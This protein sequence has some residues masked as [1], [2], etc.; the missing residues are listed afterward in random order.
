MEWLNQNSSTV[1]A[2]ATVVSAIFAGVIWWE[3]RKYRKVTER[4]KELN[5]TIVE[6]DEPNLRIEFPNEVRS[7]SSGQGK[8]HFRIP[9]WLENLCNK[10]NSLILFEAKLDNQSIRACHL[11]KRENPLDLPLEEAININSWSSST[12]TIDCAISASIG[13]KMFPTATIEVLYKTV[14]A[15]FKTIS[16]KYQL[17]NINNNFHLLKVNIIS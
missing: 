5:E 15:D 11:E 2:L 12:I 16:A 4:L 17:E 14:G 3:T 9:I 10:P 1:I 6:K 7:W 13:Q 8:A